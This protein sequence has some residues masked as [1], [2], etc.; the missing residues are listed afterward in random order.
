M[1]K[2]VLNAH[3]ELLELNDQNR[4]MFKD[5]V[6]MLESQAAEDPASS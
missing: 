6:E 2:V 4:A 5:V 3:R 1:A